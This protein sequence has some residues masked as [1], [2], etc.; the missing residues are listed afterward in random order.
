MRR[1]VRERGGW[2]GE[3]RRRESWKKFGL[4][5]AGKEEG[6]GMGAQSQ[7][8][9]EKVQRRPLR[10]RMKGDEQEESNLG[11]KGRGAKHSGAAEGEKSLRRREKTKRG[12]SFENPC[13]KKKMAGRLGGEERKKRLC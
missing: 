12:P 13:G 4:V 11:G 10:G 8:K 2:R 5:F 6:R 3:K 7:G 1:K 9:G